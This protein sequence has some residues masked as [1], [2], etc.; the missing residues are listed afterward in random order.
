MSAQVPLSTLL[1]DSQPRRHIVYP[2]N[3]EELAVN[4]VCV[5]ASSGL[6]KGESVVL[7][8]ADSHCEPIVGRLTKTGCDLEALLKSGQLEC[9]SADGFLRTFTE[10]GYLNESLFKDTIAS[11][12]E[13]ARAN[14]PA[15]QVRI[16]GEMASLL[17][18]RN[19]VAVAQRIE[20]L[21]NEIIDTHSVS[22]FCTYTLLDS[23]HPVFPDSLAKLHSH[24]LSS[25][26]HG[27]DAKTQ[28]AGGND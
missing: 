12:I 25:W 4:A 11:V 2:Y 1:T 22:L 24:H 6:S 7:I 21:W 5:F 13:R 15:R 17:F 26:L 28:S 10:S 23:A 20:E 9:L 27:S 18:S 19:E 8:M 3:D 16:F 14:S